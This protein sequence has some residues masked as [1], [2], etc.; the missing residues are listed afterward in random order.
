MKNA[1]LCIFDSIIFVLQNT[2]Q[3]THYAHLIIRSFQ[4]FLADDKP[5]IAAGCFGVWFILFGVEQS[6]VLTIRMLKFSIN[7]FLLFFS[8]CG[9]CILYSL[10]MIFSFA[11]CYCLSHCVQ[12]ENS[13]KRVAI[14][15]FITCQYHFG[16]LS[17]I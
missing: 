7:R 2:H 9:F 17:F 13:N 4:I 10:E 8:G 6:S 15:S 5:K 1:L 3:F 14:T 12:P 16:S 11:Q